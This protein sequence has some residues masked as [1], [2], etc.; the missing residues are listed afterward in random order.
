MTEE[1]KKE[2]GKRLAEIGAELMEYAKEYAEDKHRVTI[3]I[4]G[5][6]NKGRGSRYIGH[7]CEYEVYSHDIHDQRLV[8][9]LDQEEVKDLLL[10]TRNDAPGAEKKEEA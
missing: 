10:I 1:R 9:A 3:D 2:I 6:Y 4:E 5:V 8:V 7:L